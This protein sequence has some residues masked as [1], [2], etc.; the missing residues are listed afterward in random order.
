[1]DRRP[2]I[3]RRRGVDLQPLDVNDEAAVRLLECFIWPDQETR[4]SRLRAAIEL[5]REDPPE[6]LRGDYVDLLPSLLADRDPAV[7]T[8]V[9]QSVSTVYLSGERYAQLRQVVDR[10]DP[11]VAWISTRRFDEEETNVESGFELELKLPHED[12]SRLVAH[13]GYHGQWLEWTGP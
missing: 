3:I 10:A 6:L 11:P 9:F 1:M 13:M 4:M 12:R 7:V 2:L 5:A 8:V